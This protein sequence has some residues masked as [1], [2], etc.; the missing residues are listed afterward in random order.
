MP[1]EAKKVSRTIYDRDDQEVC[2]SP[3]GAQV[4][5]PLGCDDPWCEGCWKCG[6]HHPKTSKSSGCEGFDK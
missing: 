1:F 4:S 6:L 2:K 3:C 5:D